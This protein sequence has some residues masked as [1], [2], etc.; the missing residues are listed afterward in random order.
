MFL[1]IDIGNTNQKV[2]VFDEADTMMDFFQSQKLEIPTVEHLLQQ[3]SISAAI[4][5]SVGETA[6]ELTHWLSKKVSVLSFTTELK[7]P[8]GIRYLS[9][10]TLGTDRLANAIGANSLYPNQNVLAIQLG[11]CLV[12][13]F[14]NAENQYVGGSIAPGMRMR[15]EAL[16]QHTARLPLV[17]SRAIDDIVGKTTEESIL[18]GVIIGMAAEI[19]GIISR[20]ESQNDNLQIV[21]TGGDL[22]F[23]QS[24]IKKRIFAAPNLVLWGLYKT[25]LLNVSKIR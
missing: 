14:I 4:I 21:V 3:Y 17:T 23:L 18:S 20:Y 1:I 16:H 12:C 9:P 11:T 7:L 6:A 2:A 22:N 25:L 19:E 10:E 5:S 13:D 15:F 24:F 8:V